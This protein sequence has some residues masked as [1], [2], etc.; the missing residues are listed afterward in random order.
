[1]L[2]RGVTQLGR[3]LGLGPRCRMFKSCHLDHQKKTP[4][5][6]FFGGRNDAFLSERDARLRRVIH[7]VSDARL[8]ARERTQRITAR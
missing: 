2:F 3:V 8:T 6:S 5:G 1:M 7:F 4:R